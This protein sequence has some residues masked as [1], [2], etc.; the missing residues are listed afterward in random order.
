MNVLILWSTYC[1]YHEIVFLLLLCVICTSC[2]CDSTQ[3][4]ETIVVVETPEKR[5][6]DAYS[7]CP[8]VDAQYKLDFTVRDSHGELHIDTF[9]L[10]II[11]IRGESYP[12]HGAGVLAADGP[13]GGFNKSCY[14]ENGTA[15][16]V[17]VRF[18]LSSRRDGY[19]ELKL[20]E[21]VWATTGRRTSVEL[22]HDCHAT[23]TFVKLGTN[24]SA[25]NH[26]LQP[27]NQ[28][29]RTEMDDQSFLPAGR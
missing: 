23:F 19:P 1:F 22:P 3:P 13:D 14:I 26:P 25:G 20:N 17:A 28:V 6:R 21:I 18:W 5:E 29:G 4:T 16:S 2:G 27:S 9:Y 10:R 24:Q 12:Y 11:P 15:T 7:V 8:Q